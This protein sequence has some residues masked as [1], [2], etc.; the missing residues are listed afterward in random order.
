VH[1]RNVHGSGTETESGSKLVDYDLVP[2]ELFDI[3][4]DAVTLGEFV[5]ISG[6]GFVGGSSDASTLLELS[7]S[8]EADGQ[9][10]VNID[11]ALVPEFVAGREL[12]Y[13]INEDDALGQSLDLR[14]TPGHFSG[15]IRPVVSFG[16]STVTGEARP[17]EIDL[18][19]V[20]QVVYVDF[21]APYVAAL[22]DYGLRA[23]D[24]DL[25]TLVAEVVARDYQGV[26]LEL[27]LEE[28][29]DYALYSTV[30]IGGSDPNALGLLGYDNT[31]GKDVGNDRL[32]D[33]IG[34]VN[35]TTQ[36]DGYPGFGGVFIESLFIFSEH[37]GEH[38]G[39][40]AVSDSRFD[41]VFDPFRPD[42]GGQPVRAADLAGGI[43]LSAGVAACGSSDRSSQMVCAAQVLANLI[44]TTVSHELG[45]SLGLAN[46]DGSNIHNLS[47]APNRIM[48]AG[49]AR[50]F[51]ERAELDGQ[52]PGRFCDEAY[53]YLRTILPS[54]EAP[55]PVDRPTCF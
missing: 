52:G 31:P 17:F 20:K 27:R 36:Q 22:Q 18:A 19:P 55:D 6:A 33:R 42:R 21:T 1:L 13:A 12:R 14:Y 26:N 5:T 40:A 49:G 25:R 45:H 23:L 50:P 3:G 30:E 15:Q 41:E 29:T 43:D 35:A 46:P 28:P 48:D 38:A 34:G 9:R 32:H 4:P 11:L 7:G 2:T 39:S 16:D 24:A 54:S 51:A 37:P 10:P 53:D 8:F 44:G 47:D